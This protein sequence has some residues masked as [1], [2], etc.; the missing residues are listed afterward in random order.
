MLLASTILQKMA[1]KEQFSGV[2]GKSCK[3]CKS[4]NPTFCDLVPVSFH[5]SYQIGKAFIFNKNEGK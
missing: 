5:I 3:W 1:D 2:S 4:L